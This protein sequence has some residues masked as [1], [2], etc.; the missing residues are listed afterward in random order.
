MVGLK[1]HC[2]LECVQKF[3]NKTIVSSYINRCLNVGSALFDR[4]PY[5]SSCAFFC[6]KI[7][8]RAQTCFVLPASNTSTHTKL[9]IYRANFFSIEPIFFNPHL[10]THRSFCNETQVHFRHNPEGKFSPPP[11]EATDERKSLKNLIPGW[12]R[13]PKPPPE[14]KFHSIGTGPGATT[15]GRHNPSTGTLVKIDL[16]QDK[17][18]DALDRLSTVQINIKFSMRSCTKRVICSL[19]TSSMTLP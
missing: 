11:S 17:V 1:V 15:Y 2:M 3:R 16:L 13:E 4:W 5:W 19:P 7:F 9:K 18:I 8:V 6:T 10:F 12:N 14:P